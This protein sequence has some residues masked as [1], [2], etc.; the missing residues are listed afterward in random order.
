MKF[1]FKF[2]E[3]NKKLFKK[4]SKKFDEIKKKLTKF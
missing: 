3:I 2:D 4:L 1:F